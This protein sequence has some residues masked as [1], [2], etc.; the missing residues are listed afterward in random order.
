[1]QTNNVDYAW[2]LCDYLKTASYRGA[3][4]AY[5]EFLNDPHLDP[6]VVAQAGLHDR[7]FLMTVVLNLQHVIFDLCVHPEWIY[8]RCREV[9]AKPDN[10]LDLWA[11]EHFKSTII[12]FAGSIQEIAK[13]SAIYQDLFPSDAYFRGKGQEITIGL[14]SHNTKIARD[15][16]YKIK[17]ELEG[18]DL[19]KQLYPDVF[20]DNPGKDSPRWSVDH[21]LI[22]KRHANPNEPTLSGWGLVDSLPTSKHFKLSIYDDTVTEKSVTTAE[23]ILKTTTAW[24]LA[25]FLSARIDLDLPPRKWYIGT[26]YNYADTYSVMLAR[27]VAEPRI[28]PATD[29]GSVDGKPVLLSEE[30]WADRKKGQSTYVLACQMLQ[31]PLA[32]SL[33]E[34]DDE[35][36]RP[37]ELRPPLLNVYILTDPADS[38]EVNACNTAFVVMGIDSAR[39]KYILDGACHKMSLSERW[40]MLKRLRFKWVNTKGVRIVRVC[41]EKYGMQS[42]ISHFEEMM[43]LEKYHFQ[44]EQI[45]SKGT[46]VIAKDDRIR[47]LEPDARNWRLFVPYDGPETSAQKAAVA[48]GKSYLISKPILRKNEDGRLYDLIQYLK[49]NEWSFFPSTTRKDLMDGMSQ[50]YDVDNLTAPPQEGRYESMLPEHAEDI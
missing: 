9:E 20:W 30:Q 8:E 7:F 32:G 6:Y 28:H 46:A 42:D 26:R 29:D 22:C 16:V 44:I 43:R 14:F 17:S 37:Y 34:F 47:R 33:Q 40:T 49:D 10:C 4:S 24:E 19:L 41:Y 5:D 45:P 27:E 35:W 2:E 48:L 23:M 13:D 31:N 12:T 50:I 3:L 36:L 18:N 21:G 11:R 15:F 39:N 38:K 25:D 1:M